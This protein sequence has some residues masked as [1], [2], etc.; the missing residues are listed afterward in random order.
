MIGLFDG[1]SALALA[2]GLLADLLAAVLAETALTVDDAPLAAFT[3]AVLLDLVEGL[4][5]AFV[6][7]SS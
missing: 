6:T 7:G 5:V 2:V 4:A 1:V 3:G